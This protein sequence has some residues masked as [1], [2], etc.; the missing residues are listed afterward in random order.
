MEKQKRFAV[1]DGTALKLIA[2]VSMVFDHV[3]DS[4]FPE[5]V[6]MRVVG[7]IAMPL[8]AFCIAEG[9]LHT[10]DRRRY[11]QRMG[12]F[13][14]IS[15]IPFS[16]VTSGKVLDV[17]HLNIMWTFFWAILALLCFER[18]LSICTKHDMIKKTEVSL[19]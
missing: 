18:I 9:F 7:R 5:Q 14:L 10:H 6:W 2:M 3:G 19:C 13:A 12:L 15:E 16:L 8:F 17:S 1:L 4:F 11:L